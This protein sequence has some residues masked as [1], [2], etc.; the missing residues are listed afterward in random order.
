MLNRK[1]GLLVTIAIMCVLGIGCSAEMYKW[2][3]QQGETHLGN[4]PPNVNS[5]VEIYTTSWCPYCTHAKEYLKSRGVPYIE[6]DVAKSRDALRRKNRL[7]PSD[8]VPVA[9]I[10]GKVIDGF[11]ETTYDAAL[12]EKP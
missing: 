4:Y 2:V 7:S 10:N 11:S 6:Y 9:V 3:D 5:N 8:R 1:K 12:R